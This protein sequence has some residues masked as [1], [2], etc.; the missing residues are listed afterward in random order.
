VDFRMACRMHDYGKELIRLGLLP[1]SA[2][3]SVDALFRK[4]LHDHTCMSVGEPDRTDCRATA[5]GYWFAVVTFGELHGPVV[6][7]L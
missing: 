7:T 2:D 3:G 4:A 6:G 5:I 1:S